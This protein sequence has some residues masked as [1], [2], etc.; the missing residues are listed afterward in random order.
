[1]VP[2]FY[3]NALSLL[4]PYYLKNPRI[5]PHDVLVPIITKVEGAW[6]VVLHRIDEKALLTLHT[7]Q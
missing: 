4:V 2:P 7:Y 6:Q 1:M 3:H 5:A